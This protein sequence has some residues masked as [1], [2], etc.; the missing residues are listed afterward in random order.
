M[1]HMICA[2]K[3]LSLTNL[4]RNVKNAILTLLAENIDYFSVNVFV[5]YPEIGAAQQS[6]HSDRSKPTL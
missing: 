6:K 5:G 2:N 3:V 1:L 4:L